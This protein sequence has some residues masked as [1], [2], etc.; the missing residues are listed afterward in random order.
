MVS[1][2]ELAVLSALDTPMSISDLAETLERSPGHVSRTV[3]TLAET[4]LVTVEREG[5]SKIVR[6]AMVEPVRVYRS[7]VHRYPHVEFPDLLTKTAIPILYFLDEPITVSE[8]ADRTDN[9]RNTVHRIVTRF[10]HWGMLQKQAGTYVLNDGFA[11]LNTFA[12]ALVSHLHIV[13]APTETGTILWETVDEYVLQTEAT[14]DDPDYLLTGPHRFAEYGLGLLTTDR[15][16]YFYS[17]R[18]DEVTVEDVVCHMLLIDD[19]ARYR[20]YCLLLLAAEGYDQDTLDERAA[21][22]GLSGIIDELV[23]YL[24][25]RGEHDPPGIVSWTEFEQLAADYGVDV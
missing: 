3:S 16:H 22:Y 2:S 1:Q 23:E 11:D 5:N 19:G 7:L 14:I 6:P 13:T 4:E 17:E 9:Y 12:R 18:R 15:R 25:T 8:L 10:Q 24:E 21:H 20:G